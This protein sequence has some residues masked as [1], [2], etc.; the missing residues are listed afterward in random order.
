MTVSR[1]KVN[2]LLLIAVTLSYSLTWIPAQILGVDGEKLSLIR[3]VGVPLII[4]SF[5]L[6]PDSYAKVFKNRIISAFVL[7]ALL[8]MGLGIILGSLSFSTIVSF[9][10]SVLAI[11]FYARQPDYFMIR[12]VIFC[13]FLG[14]ISVCILTILAQVGLVRPIENVEIEMA[15]TGLIYKRSWAGLPSSLIGPWLIL[16]LSYSVISG[17]YK[18]KILILSAIGVFV[19]FLVSF[20]NAQ[21]STVFSLIIAFILCTGL[22]YLHLKHQPADIRIKIHL[23]SGLLNAASIILMFL[24]LFGIV[25]PD[26]ST[27]KYRIDSTF[28]N[29]GYYGAEARLL[30]WEYFLT[31]LV[32]NP[33]IVGKEDIEMAEKVGAGTHIFLGESFYYGGVLLF[34]CVVVIIFSS[35]NY[36]QKKLKDPLSPFESEIILILSSTLIACLIYLTVMPGLFSRLPYILLGI[37]QG[38]KKK[39]Y[40]KKYMKSRKM[41]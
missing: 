22:Y 38:L 16:L 25:R 27:I 2:E 36:L 37:T 29:E 35:L 3:L 13:L 11:L 39:D 18:R 5:I 41:E 9:V 19:S 34:V 24:I 17:L 32:K 21:R 26:I 14:S 8:G 10:P 33:H 7:S 23:K 6:E 12:K 15:N 4:I 31:D 20:Y 40:D 28:R 30:M 1:L